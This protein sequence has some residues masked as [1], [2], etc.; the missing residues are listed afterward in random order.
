MPADTDIIHLSV[1]GT[2]IVILDKAEAATE[3][4]EKRSHMYSSR[5]IEL[6]FPHIRC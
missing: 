2:S 3:L 1:A 4:L 6:C 5:W